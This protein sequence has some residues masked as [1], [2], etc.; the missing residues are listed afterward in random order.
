MSTR[1]RGHR[2][3][4]GIESHCRHSAMQL[5]RS[6][7]NYG[8]TMVSTTPISTPTSSKY[9]EPQSTLQSTPRAMLVKR[10]NPSLGPVFQLVAG[11]EGG[12][13]E[14]P[15]SGVSVGRSSVLMVS[16][17]RPHRGGRGSL[18]SVRE[19]CP[20]PR[21]VLHWAQLSQCLSVILAPPH[22]HRSSPQRHCV[23]TFSL[24]SRPCNN[25]TAVR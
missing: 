19:P 21:Q 9:P 1:H 22:R 12:S 3:P 6:A 20:T 24:S 23:A 17:R 15:V 4:V 7:A 11:F 18:A 14:D 8:Q 10:P 25:A 5:L 2:P 13:F 16:C